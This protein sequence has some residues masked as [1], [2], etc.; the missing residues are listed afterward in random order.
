MNA[1]PNVEHEKRL[2]EA[3]RSA[4]AEKFQIGDVIEFEK[5]DGRRWILTI[6]GGSPA[7]YD[8]MAYDGRPHHLTGDATFLE[9]LRITNVSRMDD[10]T[11]DMYR[12][13]L[14]LEAAI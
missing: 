13:L 14:G 10:E 2:A 12:A 1:H 6:L 8:L 11:V 9:S 7:M 4:D 3:L 5:A